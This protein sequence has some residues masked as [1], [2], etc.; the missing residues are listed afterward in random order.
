MLSALAHCELQKGRGRGAHAWLRALEDECDHRSGHRGCFD[1]PS[2]QVFL[3]LA[4]LSDYELDL[5]SADV[6]AAPRAEHLATATANGRDGVGDAVP[7]GALDAATLSGAHSPFLSAHRKLVAALRQRQLGLTDLARFN[8]SRAESEFAECGAA[9]WSR[10]AAAQLGGHMRS[11][12]PPEVSIR[13]S[14]ATPDA[15]E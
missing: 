15:A 14:P 2:L 13:E 8:F 11:E 1:W 3:Q 4:L 6:P 10:L 5:G 12:A 7:P 9:G